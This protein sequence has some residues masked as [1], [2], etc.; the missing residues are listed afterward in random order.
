MKGAFFVNAFIAV[1]PEIVSLSLDQVG[2]KPG[3][4]QRVEVGEGSHE[5][6]DRDAGRG[7][8]ADERLQVFSQPPEFSPKPDSVS[9]SL[10]PGFSRK[11]A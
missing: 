6:G 1:G 10:I 5:R 2:G 7:G 9:R 3:A 11:L 4:A 8:A